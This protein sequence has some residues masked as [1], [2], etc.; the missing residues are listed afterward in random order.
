MFET[1]VSVYILR[2]NDGSLYVGST[3][4]LRIRV[5][6]HQD[7]RHRIGLHAYPPPGDARLL[8]AAG[9]CVRGEGTRAA[10]EA[11]DSQEE[12]SFDRS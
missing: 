2:C 10:T 3:D 8:R 9:V 6:K 11:L 1:M 12:G 7:G 4:D 5:M